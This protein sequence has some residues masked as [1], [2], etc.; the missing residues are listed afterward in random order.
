MH[1]L[2]FLNRFDS[3]VFH[4]FENIVFF[5]LNYGSNRASFSLITRK[6]LEYDGILLEK[7]SK[8]LTPNISDVTIA[9]NGVR[10]PSSTSSQRDKEEISSLRFLTIQK[11]DDQ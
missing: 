4:T 5:L 7:H 2:I 6:I 8:F 9:K 3:I 11:N 1:S 10:H